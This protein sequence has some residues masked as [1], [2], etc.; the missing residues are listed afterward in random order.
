MDG[1]QEARPSPHSLGPA[2]F[3]APH[4]HWRKGGEDKASQ[5]SFPGSHTQ[6]GPC[7]LLPGLLLVGLHPT[8]LE[9]EKSPVVTR[10]HTSDAR[11]RAGGPWVGGM[12]GPREGAADLGVPG[13]AGLQQGLDGADPLCEPRVLRPGLVQ[14]PVETT[15]LLTRAPHLGLGGLQLAVQLCRGAA[16]G[17]GVGVASMGVPGCPAHTRGLETHA[18]PGAACQLVESHRQASAHQ[19]TTKRPQRLATTGFDQA[20]AAESKPCSWETSSCR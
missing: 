14:L 16:G 4:R 9:R 15:Q 10:R 12:E 11:H 13:L 5:G 18:A 17:S 20:S 3:P 1:Q 8:G 2:L 19:G 7:P 6:L